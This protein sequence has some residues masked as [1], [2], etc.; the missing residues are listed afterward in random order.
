MENTAT[1]MIGI[2]KIKIYICNTSHTSYIFQA[3]MTINFKY[4]DLFG[5]NLLCKCQLT[6]QRIV[7]T[8]NKFIA[9]H[10]DKFSVLKYWPNEV[11]D[12]VINFADKKKLKTVVHCTL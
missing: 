11:N 8:T 2:E 9:C 1:D 5:R 6:E 10:G 4:R 3:I 12:L 7:L